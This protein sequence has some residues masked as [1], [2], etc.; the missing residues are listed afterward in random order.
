MPPDILGVTNTYGNPRV[1]FNHLHGSFSLPEACSFMRL[2][3]KCILW[4]PDHPFLSGDKA[5]PP[6]GPADLRVLRGPSPE[7]TV[8]VCSW[9]LEVV[10]IS[11][12]DRNPRVGV[13]FL[14]VCWTAEACWADLVGSAL[15]TNIIHHNQVVESVF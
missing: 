6:S 10:C 3:E 2:E 12:A 9:A 11:T 15:F 14:G 8:K 5:K 4:P 1:S 7:F 13:S